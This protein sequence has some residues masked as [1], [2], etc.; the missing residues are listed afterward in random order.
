MWLWV[1]YIHS[2]TN[3]MCLLLLFTAG[4][5][6]ACSLHVTGAKEY[7]FPQGTNIHSYPLI[8]VPPPPPTPY[9]EFVNNISPPSLQHKRILSVILLVS[10]TYVHSPHFCD[11]NDLHKLY[12]KYQQ[13]YSGFAP[14]IINDIPTGN[15]VAKCDPTHVQRFGPSIISGNF[16][17]TCPE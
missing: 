17:L 3:R 11:G 1:W 13:T 16:S 2:Y 9:K 10:T 5:N 14:G 8:L 7:L 15:G 6:L 4:R 12:I